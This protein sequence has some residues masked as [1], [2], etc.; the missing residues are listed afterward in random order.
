[1][2]STRY[3]LQTWEETMSTQIRLTCELFPQ[4]APL[5]PGLEN[6]EFLDNLH[7]IL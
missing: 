4:F 6:P 2:Q 7:L 1:M 5:F 3:E